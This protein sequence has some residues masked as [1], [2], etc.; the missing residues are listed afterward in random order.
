MNNQRG[1]SPCYNQD[2]KDTKQ[3]NNIK[4]Y[5][6]KT[7]TDINGKLTE[8]TALPS[9]ELKAKKAWAN[10]HQVLKVKNLAVPQRCL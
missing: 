4:S 6:T 2:V 8:I 3:R 9:T 1:N 10:T 5:K 7:P